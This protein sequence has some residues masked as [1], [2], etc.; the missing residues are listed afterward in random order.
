MIAQERNNI[1][2]LSIG[3]ALANN[4]ELHGLLDKTGVTNVLNEAR[5]FTI[6]VSRQSVLKPF[7][8]VEKAYMTSDYGKKDLT[9]F[10]KYM[11]LEGPNYGSDFPSGKTTCEYTHLKYNS[12]H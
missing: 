8:P 1:D 10:L 5:P 6:F 11:I 9:T 4:E 12:I 7:N 2:I 3:D